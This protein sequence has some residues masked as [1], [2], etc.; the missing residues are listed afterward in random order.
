MRH[1]DL[2]AHDG[3][4]RRG[5][6][7]HKVTRNTATFSAVV[8]V[9]F[10]CMYLQMTNGP[11][12]VGLSLCPLED[13]GK[14]LSGA[15]EST[16]EDEFNVKMMISEGRVCA[17]VYIVCVVRIVRASARTVAPICII[18]SSPLSSPAATVT[19]EENNGGLR[20]TIL[21]HRAI[22]F[23]KHT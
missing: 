11:Q 6:L 8:V 22:L 7:W 10:Y 14:S 18:L 23:I 2:I 17:C 19:E 12:V 9:V 20:M 16:F 21:H 4:T 3:E 13:E 5:E 15:L 1:H